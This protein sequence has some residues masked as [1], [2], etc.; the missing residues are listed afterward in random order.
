MSLADFLKEEL[1]DDTVFTI[2]VG[3]GIGISESTAVSWVVMAVIILLC[4]ILGSKIGR[5]H[6]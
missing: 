2:P 1:V 5:A 3:K 6:V 4:I